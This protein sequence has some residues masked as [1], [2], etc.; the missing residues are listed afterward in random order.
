[1]AAF[2]AMTIVGYLSSRLMI[3]GTW[4]KALDD[5]SVRGKQERTADAP[6]LLHHPLILRRQVLRVEDVFGFRLGLEVER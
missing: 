3:P 2:A 4:H 6:P 1:M 5:S